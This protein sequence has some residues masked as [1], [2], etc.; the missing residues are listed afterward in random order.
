[1][2]YTEVKSELLFDTPAPMSQATLA[3]GTRVLN[4]SGQTAQDAAGGTVAADIEGQTE[5]CLKNIKALVEQAGGSLAD[6]SRLAIYLTSRD[7]F[8]KVMEV[9]R[10]FF[11]APYPATTAVIAAG[12]AKEEW[13]IE[14]EATAY[15]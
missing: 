3:T 15:L 11:S 14:V 10:R 2:P 1:M 6:V 5:Q 9:R 8:P 4:I 13:L 12:L 7:Q